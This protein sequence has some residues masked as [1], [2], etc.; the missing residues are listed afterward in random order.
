MNNLH[1]TTQLIIL[2]FV[3]QPFVNHCICTEN[4]RVALLYCV[5]LLNLE[6]SLKR[7]T[8]APF[9]FPCLCWKLSLNKKSHK[10]N[11]CTDYEFVG[12]GSWG[13]GDKMNNSL[14]FPFS[15]LVVW[16]REWRWWQGKTFFCLFSPPHEVYVR[17][18]E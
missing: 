12:G 13:K 18:C 3:F 1:S 16:Q 2:L 10:N 7:H 8:F 4:S 14:C 15:S 9:I 5:L 11:I 6:N 17:S